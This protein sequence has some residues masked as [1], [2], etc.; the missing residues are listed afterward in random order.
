M[1]Y[2]LAS[3]I[4]YIF[5]CAVAA[6]TYE[7]D[8]TVLYLQT[9]RY[10]HKLYSQ[11]QLQSQLPTDVMYLA[12]DYPRH[13]TCAAR[14]PHQLFDA[15]IQLEAYRQRAVRCVSKAYQLMEAALAKGMD[16]SDAWNAT[17]VEWVQAAKAHCHL[18]VLQMF[19]KAVHMLEMCPNNQHIFKAL[20]DLFALHGIVENGRDFYQD[21][22]MSSEQMDMV[23]SQVYDLLTII[24]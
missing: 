17:S 11:K 24:R 6:Q 23:Q 8:N 16:Q 2:S 20:R 4:P 7:G 15:H 12:S 21:G 5:V 1:G 9:A 22:Y 3:G 10:L 18:S 13:K 19:T 14:T